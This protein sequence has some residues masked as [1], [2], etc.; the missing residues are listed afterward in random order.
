ADGRADGDLEP[1]G[2][3]VELRVRAPAP[4]CPPSGRDECAAVCE[5]VDGFEDRGLGEAGPGPQLR[6]GERSGLAE[7]FEHMVVVRAQCGVRVPG[8]DHSASWSTGR[9]AISIASA[10][11]AGR[12]YRR[13]KIRCIGGV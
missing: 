5:A 7:T 2:D 13:T 12:S 6:A 4:P 11:R 9:A 8:G 10:V 3:V 1:R